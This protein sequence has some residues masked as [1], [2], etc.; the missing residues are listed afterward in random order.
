MYESPLHII[1]D[2]SLDVAPAQ[3]ETANLLRLRKRLL[4][5]FG[6]TVGSY[7]T[8]IAGVSAGDLAHLSYPER[9]ALAEQ[10]DVRCPDAAAVDA[11]IGRILADEGPIVAVVGLLCTFLVLV[12][13]FIMI[14]L[15]KK[16]K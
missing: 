13:V 15:L 6:I 16:I 1:S 3:L 8:M 12:L 11:L 2:Y 14:K 7:V 4:A 10:N 5:E 9:F